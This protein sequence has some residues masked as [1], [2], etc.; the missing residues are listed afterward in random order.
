MNVHFVL[1]LCA[2]LL[3]VT[4]STLVSLCHKLH[5]TR[6]FR[7]FRKLFV[8]VCCMSS[9]KEQEKNS[10]ESKRCTV[11]LG[12]DDG[13]TCVSGRWNDTFTQLF[14]FQTIT[15]YECTRNTQF[16]EYWN[17]H[18]QNQHHQQWQRF[19]RIDLKMCSSCEKKNEAKNHIKEGAKWKYC[20]DFALLPLISTF[21]FV[22]D[23]TYNGERTIGNIIT[24]RHVT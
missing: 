20:S 22:I 10:T 5:Y 16:L 15:K 7:I 1:A 3:C 11:D 19:Q 6:N 21:A 2:S 24:I 13:G 14:E 4:L 12:G 17:Q 23:L 18:H 8:C 9:Q